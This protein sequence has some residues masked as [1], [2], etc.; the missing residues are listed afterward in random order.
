MRKSFCA[1][2]LFLAM[3]FILAGCR[4]EHNWIEATCTDVKYCAECD[5]VEGLA[6]G[7]DWQDAGCITPKTCT[8]CSEVDGLALGHDWNNAD[9]ITPKTCSECGETDGE[10][11]GHDWQAATYD[12]PKTCSLC[13]KTDG[14]PL[15]KAETPANKPET[16]ATDNTAATPTTPTADVP[17]TT[18]SSK[19]QEL[20]NLI[21]AKRI[22]K[23]LTALTMSDKITSAMQEL[24][25]D[26]DM[27]HMTRPD[28]TNRSDVIGK[29]GISPGGWYGLDT[30]GGPN[31]SAQ[32]VYDSIENGSYS[33][34]PEWGMFFNPNY[35]YIGV[36]YTKYGK[37]DHWAIFVSESH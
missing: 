34:E 4:H 8:V 33:G 2:T 11:L 26:S 17:I 31:V 15:V 19:P 37:N 18:S 14:E 22:E 7:H 20:I 10:P 29:Y 1:V 36:G 9:C 32:N 24:T 5:E 21:N 30:A 27:S 35:K 13:S 25:T 3:P 28:G 16:P 12:A 6:L 23:G